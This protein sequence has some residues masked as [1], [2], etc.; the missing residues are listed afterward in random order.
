MPQFAVGDIWGEIGKA[1][2]ILV[3]A[4]SYINNAGRLVMGRGAAREAAIRWPSLPRQLA[5]WIVK[6]GPGHL[7]EYGVIF[8]LDIVAFSGLVTF[9]PMDIGVFQVKRHFKDNAD[10]ELIRRSVD[11]LNE[12]A[13]RYDRIALNFP[14]IG[15]GRLR[16]EDVKPLLESLP[17]NVV[18]YK[19]EG[20]P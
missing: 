7:G 14:G 1:S 4:N 18:I 5:D 15:N 17:D 10:P 9:D 2:A 8:V 6:F 16:E 20:H 19:K 11:K 13:E 3:T 12:D